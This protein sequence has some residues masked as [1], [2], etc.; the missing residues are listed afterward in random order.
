[1]EM[2]RQEKLIWALMAGILIILFLLSSTDLIIK[3]KETTIYSVSVI[4][5]DTNDDYYKNFRKGI[6]KAADEYNVDVNF[7]TLYEKEDVAEQMELL[8]R[9]ISDG[10]QAV[11][12]VPLK[13]AEC[14]R[15]LDDMVLTSP[16]IIMGNSLPGDWAI[17]GISQD[18]Y[19]AG[20]MLGEAI[21][22]ENNPDKPVYMFTEGLDFGYN[23]EVYNG[24]LEEISQAGFQAHHY[25][26][27]P[28]GSPNTPVIEN[29]DFFSQV[30]ADEVAACDD[31]A[32]IVALDVK[33]LDLTADIIADNTA[34]E[35]IAVLYGFGSTTKILNQMDRGFIKGL[36]ATNQYDAG[37]LS[38][39]KAV[40]AIEKSSD[41]EQIELTSYY[42]EK[43]DLKEKYFEKI[44]YP[45]E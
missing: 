40:E 12:F 31:G 27:S 15:I 29:E 18:Y 5:K 24:L 8:N 30:M 4:I 36:I 19:E 11:V 17:T 14:R 32:I 42:L 6:D 22:R 16:L 35:N 44:L 9:E 26:M 33:S 2:T 28:S 10:S 43:D 23:Q 1:M 45:I 3:E 41:R 34:Y 20:R 37:Y 38:I 25:E 13:Q 39:V 21:V 7:I